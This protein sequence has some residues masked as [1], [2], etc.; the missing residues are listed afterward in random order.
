MPIKRRDAGWSGN[1]NPQQAETVNLSF[2]GLYTYPNQ[3]SP[4]DVPSGALQE[5]TNCVLQRPGVVDSRRGF[6][7]YAPTDG[8]PSQGLTFTSFKGNR[9]CYF[10]DNKWRQDNG[11]GQFVTLSGNLTFGLA[12]SYQGC[13]TRTG[14]SNGNLY[15]NSNLGIYKIEGLS[16]TPK[17]AGGPQA[18]GGFGTANSA[19]NTGPL[20]LFAS[21]NYRI[22]WSYTDKNSNLIRGVPSTPITVYNANSTNSAIVTLSFTTPT[23]VDTSWT[24]GVYRSNYGQDP[25]GLSPGIP[26]DNCQLVASGNPTSGQLTARTISIVDTVADNQRGETI[27]TTTE[28]IAA[29]EYRP[30]FAQDMALF[31]G[32]MFYTNTKSFQQ[33]FLNIINDGVLANNDTLTF[34]S[35]V[36]TLFT[37]TASTTENISTGHFLIGSGGTAQQN[38][39]VTGLSICRVLNYYALNTVMDAY[40]ESVINVTATGSMLFQYRAYNDTPFYVVCSNT[41]YIF[42]PALPASGSNI[43]NTSSD[44]NAQNYLYFSKSL[45]PEAVPLNYFLAVGDKN[46]PVLRLMPMRDTLIAIKSDGIYGI[47]GSDPTSFTVQPFDVQQNLAGINTPAVLNN[48][49]YFLGQQG[50]VQ[51]DEYGNHSI[52]SI[53]I[54]DDLLQYTTANYPNFEAATWALSYQADREYVLWTVASPGDTT[55][56]QAFVYN[57][58]TQGWTKWQKNFTCGF[59]DPNLGTM[60]T[61]NFAASTCQIYQERKTLTSFDY[62]DEALPLIITNVA[63]NVLTVNS[64]PTGTTIGC[65]IFQSPFFSVI[66]AI[67]AGNNRITVEDAFSWTA[68]AAIVAVPIPVTITTIPVDAQDPTVQKQFT[69]YSILVD[70]TAE[71]HFNITFITDALQI[72]QT[73]N[74]TVPPSLAP[75]GTVPFGLGV[76]GNTS[77]ANPAIRL[78][79]FVPKNSQKCNWLQVTFHISEAF[80]KVAFSAMKLTYRP[81][82]V[83]QRT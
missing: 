7:V 1:A 35:G 22:L 57:Y 34:K 42:N 54:Q 29:S 23:T 8:T 47:T 2:K 43:N 31:K 83:R 39:N 10:D 73:Q 72:G 25:T 79:N 37:L 62:F 68:A 71:A 26:D 19:A 74:I 16:S 13:R 33:F 55:A 78:H 11:S 15:F 32:S 44:T 27:Y 40:Y 59:V 82:S 77:L 30:P 63:G 64:V 12:G 61:T 46:T 9:F 20:P 52:I 67:D 38:I 70:G 69:T 66:S 45:Q 18:L 50:V 56:Q 60:W 76:F 6:G 4:G 65:S 48:I 49:L 24:Y 75:F 14:Q 81:L 41:G 28:G 3:F 21:V 5:A 36:T 51:M 58:V 53:P 80:N 17:L